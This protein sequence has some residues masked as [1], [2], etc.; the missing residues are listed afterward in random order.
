MENIIRL[1]RNEFGWFCGFEGPHSVEVED[2][3]GTNTIPCGFTARAS[4]EVVLEEIR[5]RNP[6]IEVVLA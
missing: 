1:T 2:L 3:F 5:A 4:S 6:G